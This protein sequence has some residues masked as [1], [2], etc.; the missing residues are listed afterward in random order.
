M[1]NHLK[2]KTVK[3]YPGRGRGN[4]GREYKNKAPENAPKPPETPSKNV[5][6]NPE[7]NV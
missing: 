3:T 4:F 6:I 5:P 7:E 2:A 1:M